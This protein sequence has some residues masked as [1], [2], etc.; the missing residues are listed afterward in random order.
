MY[1]LR[2]LLY[3]S[4]ETAHMFLSLIL[5][6]RLSLC[7]FWEI[8]LIEKQ[9][10]VFCKGCSQHY[11]AHVRHPLFLPGATCPV[12]VHPQR[13]P[14]LVIFLLKLSEPQ[15]ETARLWA[16]SSIEPTIRTFNLEDVSTDNSLEGTGLNLKWTWSGNRMLYLSFIFYLPLRSENNLLPTT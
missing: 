10:I 14:P 12:I 15:R 16:N 9:T 4:V 2:F 5:I 3:F 1:R 13:P 6:V 11:S 8:N 7:L